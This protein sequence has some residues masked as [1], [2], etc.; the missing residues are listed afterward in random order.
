[1]SH[2][3][4]LFMLAKI[5]KAAIGKRFLK[6]DMDIFNWNLYMILYQG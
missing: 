2:D 6:W 5:K 3:K 1:M 4:L